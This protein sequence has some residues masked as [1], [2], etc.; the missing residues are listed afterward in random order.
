MLPLQ[1]VIL[2]S[3]NNQL[4]TIILFCLHIFLKANSRKLVLGGKNGKFKVPD[5]DNKSVDVVGEEENG[6]ICNGFV[7]GNTSATCNII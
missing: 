5:D 6:K 2:N 4:T 7:P 1:Y 3:E